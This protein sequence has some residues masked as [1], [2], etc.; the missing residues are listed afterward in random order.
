[1][2]R[3]H[4]VEAETG[5]ELVREVLADRWPGWAGQPLVPVGGTGT[6]HAMYRVGTEH[7]AR[8]PR[9]GGAAASLEREV[10]VLPA[11]AALLPVSVP[12]VEH[13][14]SPE[15]RYQHPWAV[16]GWI[17]GRDAWAAADSVEDPHGID[18][19]HDLAHLVSSL[20]AA[21]PPD[22][23][24]RGEGLRGG[25]VGAVLERADRWL[26]GAEGPLPGWVDAAAVRAVL[27][28]AREV[29]DP[30]PPYVLSHGDLI[31]GN[32]L[33]RGRRLAAVV[34]WGYA[35]L[36][37]PALDLV[38]A[39]SLLGPAARRVFLERLAPDDATWHRARANAVEQ[40]LGALAYYTPR[41]HPL[42]DVMA[43]TL[44]RV[45]DEAAARP[46]TLRG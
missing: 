46:G 42:A 40:A 10:R 36:A 6:D 5:P 43:R 38:A 26:A 35:S 2:Q 3:I 15:G 9:T 41:R 28:G 14:G 31:P 27:D 30:V 17:E 23:P 19:A 44:R 45:L 37:D 11:V 29:Q 8:F 20:R 34:D 21:P 39:W 18:L 24:V 33:V 22:V 4:D 13:V 16:L 12:S 7:V 25:P 32:V 1:M